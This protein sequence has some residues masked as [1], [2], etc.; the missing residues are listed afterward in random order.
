MGVKLLN[1]WRSKYF[2]L[3]KYLMIRYDFNSKKWKYLQDMNYPKCNF[4]CVSSRDCSSIYAI[5]GYDNK[6]LN[7]IEK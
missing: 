6:P 5:G 7:I 4:A 1:L 3:F 2:I